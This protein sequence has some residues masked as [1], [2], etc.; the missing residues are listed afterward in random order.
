MQR[1]NILQQLLR[2]E[3]EGLAEGKCAS[4]NGSSSL[5]MVELQPLLAEISRTLNAPEK[6]PEAFH[7]PGLSQHP[8][9]PKPYFPGE[10]GEPEP[11]PGRGPGMAAPCPPAEPG[12]PESCPGRG[13]EMAPPCPPAE[14]GSPEPCPGR[15]PE[16]PEPSTQEQPEAAGP[17]PPAEPGRLQACHQGQIGLPEPSTRVDL[18]VPEACSL[19]LRNPESS[20]RPRTSQWAPATTS[21]TFSSQRPLCASP[22]IRSLQSLKPSPGPAGPSHPAPRTMALRQRL[23]ACLTAIQG[24]HEACLDDECAFY[25]SRAPPSGLTRVCTNPVAMLLEWQDALCFIPVGSAAP[26][27]SPS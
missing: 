16:N 26:Q 7:L 19:E 15:G 24:F 12:S 9:L 10:C 5:D 17:S 14:P 1:I 18:G 3:V 11:C 25:T 6:I 20:P 2:Q 8:E 22:P 4:L 21:L 13:P 27:D 23:K